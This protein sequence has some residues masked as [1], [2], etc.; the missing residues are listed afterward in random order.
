MLDDRVYRL[1]VEGKIVDRLY[2]KLKAPVAKFFSDILS[3]RYRKA[4]TRRIDWLIQSI[5]L[6]RLS[7]KTPVQN[8]K[9]LFITT[10]GSFNCNPR[11]IAEGIIR[12]ELPWKLVWAT[13]EEEFK[14]H[15]QFPK[16][17]KLV[18]KG[19]YEFYKE[20]L[21]AKVWIDNSVQMSYLNVPKKQS[22]IL[23]ET[24]HGSLGLK[25]FSTNKDRNWLKKSIAAGKR[26]DYCLSNSSF[27]SELFKSTFWK[28]SDIREY[29][30][31][32][33]DILFDNN[34][35][36]GKIISKELRDKLR[37]PDGVKVALYAPTFRDNK[38]N[39][40]FYDL[41]YPL[42]I[43]ALE[44]RFGGSWIIAVRLHYEVKRSNAKLSV[45]QSEFVIDVTDYRDIQDLL[46]IA[47]VGI[48]DYSSWVFDYVLSGKPA[49]LYANDLEAYA[50]ER[51]FLYPIEKTPFSLAKNMDEMVENILSFDSDLYS[52]ACST[53]IREKG[54]IDD[55]KAVDRTINFLI[56]IINKQ[57]D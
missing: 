56:G 32:R 51:G 10:R 11:A 54:C 26:T 27:E 38:Q 8:D 35:D 53:F 45:S 50:D 36:R 33:N 9:I 13:S 24:W 20:A 1:A 2:A 3:G 44:K 17:L 28:T 37:L 18:V 34:A 25:K 31:A 5:I 12:A 57:G 15:Q 14:N 42:L 23:I 4:L 39:L 16:Q 47:D 22:Q 30:H 46:L 43:N 49:F 21:S 55:G 7:D 29:G 41:D 6:K 19:S 52:A 40:S 48:T